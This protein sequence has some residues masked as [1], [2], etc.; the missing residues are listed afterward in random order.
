M[1]E[2]TEKEG[3]VRDTTSGGIVNND[4]A[5]LKAY[6]LKKER[7]RITQENEKRITQIENDISEIKKLISDCIA[8][9]NSMD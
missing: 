4:T 8:Q 6:K 1:Y 3:L 9:I 5:A 7:S 2:K